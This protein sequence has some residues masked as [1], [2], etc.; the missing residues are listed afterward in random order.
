[1]N[2]LIKIN[3]KLHLPA[4]LLLTIPAFPQ[5]ATVSVTTGILGRPIP[6]DFL[7]LSIEL[8]NV[9]G[10]A[11]GTP[12][13]PNTG[14]FQMI[15]NLGPGTFRLG[16]NSQDE[17]CWLSAAATPNPAGCFTVLT[18][19]DFQSYNVASSATGWKLI[20]GVNLGQNSPAWALQEIQQGLLPNVSPSQILALEIGNEPDHF[21][22]RPFRGTAS[23]NIRPRG[24]TYRNH[25][26]EYLSYTN[27]FRS[28]P[29]A[30]AL[31]F[32]GPSYAGDLGGGYTGWRDRYLGAF[33]DS[34][35]RP[36]VSLAV[37]HVYFAARDTYPGNTITIP[38]LLS[39]R[40]SDTWNSAF[41]AALSVT[42]PRGVDLQIDEINS[43]NNGGVPGVS[44][45]MAS[46]LWGL[47]TMFDF[48]S[49]GIRRINFH[50][51]R[52]AAYNPIQIDVPSPGVY[53]NTAR[54]L[55]YAMQLFSNAEGQ[56]FLSTAIETSANIKAYAVAQ[57][58]GCPVSVFVVNK[59]MVASGPVT[60]KLSS[61]MG[62]ASLLTLKA[63]ALTSLG[64]E[65]LYGGQ[66]INPAT[67]FFNGPVVTTEVFPLGLGIYSFNLDP[68]SA[69]MLTI[70]P[71]TTSP[72]AVR[73]TNNG[74]SYIS[75]ITPGSIAS[76]FGSNLSLGT[77]Y[78]A[79]FPLPFLMGGTT[80]QMA[81]VTVPQFFASPSQINFQVPWEASGSSEILVKVGSANAIS[82]NVS[83]VPF[84][85]AIFAAGQS[86]TGQGAIL[87]S[88][89]SMLAG[90]P[91]E[92]ATPVRPGEF[93]SIY[94]TG[95]GPVTNQPRT[96]SP[97]PYS[98]LA[99]TT[100]QPVV[101]I[102]NIGAEVAFSG[103]APGFVGL[104]QVNARIP[105]NVSSSD[106]V[107]VAI[108]IGGVTS[109]TVTIAVRR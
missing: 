40:L 14:F 88:G 9:K 74:A 80:L 54:P 108:S 39:Q 106:N 32:A 37:A 99:M 5:V 35:G 69:A 23:P 67:G 84:A 96:G 44:D 57:C 28:D 2:T 90:P 62:V 102:G 107:P 34:V 3:T 77:I 11:F 45:T 48:A 47:S 92:K 15:Q 7:G 95:L 75:S 24:Y 29:V 86:G 55:Y 82:A 78:N 104:Y 8:Q 30:A 76:I 31:P 98:P 18:P 87:V 42:A 16:G 58:S 56:T 100:T 63:P 26:A 46:A 49:L 36:N 27:M 97:S 73:S 89:T 25:I 13:Q 19:E 94:C 70:Q 22:S 17:S 71:S 20:F 33:L 105:P 66:Q 43:A 1:M 64:N 61:E 12:S 53:V 51:G 52:S 50:T 79:D 85:P 6:R 103:L 81:G 4:V 10:R 21:P 72:A 38:D 91:S 101:A 65:V 59:D 60:I 93:I 83:V 41:A 109:N 68:A